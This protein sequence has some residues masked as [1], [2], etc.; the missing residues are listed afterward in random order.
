MIEFPIPIL[1]GPTTC[2]CNSTTL[3]LCFEE[4]FFLAN[5]F[6]PKGWLFS[7]YHGIP[8]QDNPK[9]TKVLHRMIANYSD[10]TLAT[11]VVLVAPRN[12]TW[13]TMSHDHLQQVSETRVVLKET[14][15]RLL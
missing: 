4:P 12:C 15:S 5:C 1:L 2:V 14:L 11:H 9:A 3:H 13:A 7:A 10:C 6:K 8:D